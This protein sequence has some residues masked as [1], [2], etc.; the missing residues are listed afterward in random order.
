MEGTAH[1]ALEGGID[2]LMLLDPGYACER[3]G[4][5]PGAI[6]VSVA[7]QILYGD[8]GIGE[9]LGQVTVQGFDGHGH[10]KTLV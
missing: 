9:G 4:D 2:E 10:A 3:T 5:D 1:F 8:L 7:S 6:M